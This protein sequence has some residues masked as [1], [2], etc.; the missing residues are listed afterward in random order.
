MPFTETNRGTSLADRWTSTPTGPLLLPPRRS[1]SEKG[2]CECTPTRTARGLRR[3]RIS[4]GR[5]P[6]TTSGGTARPRLPAILSRWAPGTTPT[7]PKRPATSACSGTAQSP[8]LGRSSARTWTVRARATD[9]AALLTSP[10]MEWCWR[11]GPSLRTTMI[12]VTSASSPSTRRRTSGLSSD[13]PSMEMAPIT[14]CV[15]YPCHPM[16]GDLPRAWKRRTLS[17]DM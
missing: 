2:G 15:V 4:W 11:E 16:G 7:A 13:R 9:S 17:L 10:R 8:E 1:R 3:G 5:T 14:S 12:L 6:G